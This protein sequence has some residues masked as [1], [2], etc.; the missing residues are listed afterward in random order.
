MITNKNTS[1]PFKQHAVIYSEK[2][3][4]STQSKENEEA[5]IAGNHNTFIMNF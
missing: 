1:N 2:E 5:K 4:T 3:G